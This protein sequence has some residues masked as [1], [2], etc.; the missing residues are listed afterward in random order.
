[1]SKF[2]QILLV[3]VY[4]LL[5]SYSFAVL[6][7]L[8]GLP[9]SRPLLWGCCTAWTAYCFSS[10]YFRAGIF[11][12]HRHVRRPVKAEEDKLNG[13]FQEVLGQARMIK[14]FQLLIE[15]EMCCNAF[16]IGLRTIVVTRGSL[17]KMAPEELNAILAHELGH[18]QSKDCLVSSAFTAASFLPQIV[19]VIYDKVKFIFLQRVSI[20]ETQ[21]RVKIRF[22]LLV[23]FIGVLFYW[24]PHSVF[25]LLATFLFALACRQINR[26]FLFLWRIISRYREYR[27]DAYAY[28]LGY[29][30]GL[31]QALFKLTINEPQFVSLYEILMRGDHPVI[32]NRIR[33]LEKLEGIR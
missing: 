9:V 2:F 18:L 12:A 11:L 5:T 22:R 3:A 10:A 20:S 1:M 31:R 15:E 16:A 32:Y 6:L 21:V 7:A 33:R 29:G 24:N 26:P 4:V 17:D 25:S 28:Q 13:C 8:W 14:K 27:Q 30:K 23:L 19:T